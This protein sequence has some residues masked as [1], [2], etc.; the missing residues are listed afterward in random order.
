LIRLNL[1]SGIEQKI[2][3]IVKKFDSREK[4]FRNFSRPAATVRTKN[5]HSL[6]GLSVSKKKQKKGKTL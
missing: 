3:K 1:D 4:V 2:C 5:Y 6:G